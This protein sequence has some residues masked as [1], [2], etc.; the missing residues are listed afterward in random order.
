MNPERGPL[1]Q[2]EAEHRGRRK[3]QGKAT[4]AITRL[5]LFSQQFARSRLGAKAFSAMLQD[6]SRQSPE[7]S[8]IPN[9]EA[10]W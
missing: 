1:R 5:V 10:S 9:R 3:N 2:T 7:G 6:S 8:A 4:N